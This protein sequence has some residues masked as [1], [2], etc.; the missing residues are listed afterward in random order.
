MKPK[1]I[2]IA[3]LVVAAVFYAASWLKGDGVYLSDLTVSTMVRGMTGEAGEGKQILNKTVDEEDGQL[4][5]TATFVGE[6]GKETTLKRTQ[7]LSNWTSLLP[8]LL[9]IIL[10]ICLRRVLLS[11][12][13]AIWLGAALHYSW[14]PLK[15]IYYGAVHYLWG[16]FI[17]EF[18]LLILGFVFVLIG[19]VNVINRGGGM[20]GVVNQITRIAKS[21]K[22]ACV[23]AV[24]MGTLIF[25]DDYT[26]TIVVGT[27][28]RSF[29]DRMRVSREKLAYIVDSTSAPLAG[30]AIISTWIGFEVIQLHNVGEFLGIDKSGYSLFLQ[31]L[32]FRFYCI[33]TILFVFLICITRWDFGPMLKAERRTVETGQVHEPDVEHL[34]DPMVKAADAKSGIPQRWYNAAI[35]VATVIIFLLGS[36]L[37]RGSQL[38]AEAGESISVF[39]FAGL[40]ECFMRIGGDG[41]TLFFLML[42]AALAGTAMAAFLMLVQRILKPKE[43][44]VAFLSGWRVLPAALILIF[45][46]AIQQVCDELGTALF[47][48]SLAK[49]F[50]NPVI[51]PM[52]IF[53]LSA[54]VAFSTGTSFGTMGLMLPTVGPLAFTLGS[55]AAFV[56]S[57]GAVLDGAI[58]GDHCSPISDTTV[59]SSISSSCDLVDHVKTQMPYA[60]LCMIVAIICGYLPAAMGMSPVYLYGIGFAMLLGVLMVFGR[61][62][63]KSRL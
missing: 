34:E 61:N 37:W 27:T 35:P 24:C 6:D 49:D 54:A 29:T 44:V 52:V 48:S 57:L 13:L 45:A 30:L 41:D 51:L 31:A 56:M 60:V 32:P 40:R 15:S 4:T 55:P 7:R 25:F 58:F 63:E 33:F 3:L 10:A 5:V 21:A 22:M 18:S 17:G 36:I 19:M 12:A 8:P 9:A 43:I 23:S 14:N 47:I 38:I 11:L 2:I 26:N 62:P 28:M 39:S 16:N 42:F 46:W 20:A 50:L 53:I 1:R 59:L